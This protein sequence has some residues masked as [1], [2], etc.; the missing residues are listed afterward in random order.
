MHIFHIKLINIIINIV[1]L[2][3]CILKEAFKYVSCLKN[4]EK[5]TNSDLN[6]ECSSGSSKVPILFGEFNDQIYKYK[7]TSIMYLTYLYQCKI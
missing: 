4:Q 6:F 7:F 5:K 2:L 1:F 3:K